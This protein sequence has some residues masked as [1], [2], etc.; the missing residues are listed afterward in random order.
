[1]INVP[2]AINT[3]S[4][5]ADV[6]PTIDTLEF[7]NALNAGR[8]QGLTEDETTLHYF[9]NKL[10]DITL[11]EKD[12]HE[13]NRSFPKEAEELFSWVYLSRLHEEGVPPGWPEPK[14]IAVTRDAHQVCREV[15]F[16]FEYAVRE[17]LEFKS[18]TA[19]GQHFIKHRNEF[20]YGLEAIRFALVLKKY[21]YVS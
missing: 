2:L 8:S 15:L 13:Y 21:P 10:L 11:I 14:T 17:L 6:F 19:L 4:I 12:S 5:F 16:A 9:L 1:M 3:V 20:L 18:N 7:R